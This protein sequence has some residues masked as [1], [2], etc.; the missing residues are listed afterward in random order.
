LWY[1]FSWGNPFYVEG[2]SSRHN[3]NEKETGYANSW[4]EL[5]Q[6]QDPPPGTTAAGVLEHIHVSIIVVLKKKIGPI[7]GKYS[8]ESWKEK[9]KTLGPLLEKFKKCVLSTKLPKGM[10]WEI[11]A[12]LTYVDY[13]KWFDRVRDVRDTKD[14]YSML[15]GGGF[16]VLLA[17]LCLLG[18]GLLAGK[19]IKDALTIIN[20]GCTG[21]VGTATTGVVYITYTNHVKM[22]RHFLNCKA[23]IRTLNAGALDIVG[24]I[25]IFDAVIRMER[26]N[27]DS[28]LNAN[29][30]KDNFDAAAIEVKKHIANI[31]NKCKEAL[32]N[33]AVVDEI[34][35]LARPDQ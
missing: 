6:I 23:V 32:D 27:P 30:I 2:T 12:A 22:L 11:N 17:G 34:F 33:C 19:S 31:W 20:L 16:L 14:V 26:V 5:L 1:H 8:W 35:I 21:A 15:Q 28:A 4:L 18:H 3:T 24:Q 25:I 10:Y 13:K 9:I 29:E 7:T